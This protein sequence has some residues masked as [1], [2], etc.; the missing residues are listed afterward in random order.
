DSPGGASDA[1]KTFDV[2]SLMPVKY[3]EIRDPHLK[4]LSL[5]FDPLSGHYDDDGVS[6]K[7]LMKELNEHRLLQQSHWFSLFNPRTR[8][9]D[10]MLYNVDEHSGN[11]DTFAGNAAFFRVHVNEGFFVYASYSVVI[12]SKLTQHVVLPPLYE[13]TPHLFTNSEVIQKAYAA[14]MTQTPTKIFAHFT[15]SKS[16]PEQRVAYFGEDIGMNTHHVTWHLEFPFWWD[17]AHYDHHIER[18]GESCSSWV[19]HQLTVRFDAERLSNYL[20]PVRELH[21]DDVIHEGFAPHTSYKYG[22]Y[23]P[24]RPDN[25]NFEDVDG[26]ARVRDM[27]LF[28]ERIQ[29]AIAHGYLRYNGSTINIRDNHGIDVLGDVFE[30]SM[31]SPR[32][33]YYGALHNQAH[34]VLG[35]QADPHGKFALPPGVLEHFETAT[36]DPAFFRLHKYMDNIFRK[37]KD[38]LTPYTKNELKF[39]GVNI[40]SIYEKGNLETYF[41]SF[42]YTGVNIMLLTNDVDDVDIATY[43][44]D[45]AH[46]ELSFQEDVTNEGD[47]GVLETVRIFA[48]PHIDDDHVEFSFNEGRWDVIEMDK[49]WV[50]LEH[51]HHSIDRSSFDSTVTIPDRPSFHDIEDRTSEAI[52]HG[53]ELHIEEF[54]S[55]TG[56]P[57]RFLIP[58][59]LVK[60]KDMDVMVAVTSG[61]GLAAVE[62]LHRSAN[63]AHHGCPE[64][65]Y[66]DKRPHGYPLYRPVDDERII[67]GVTNFK[68]IQVKVFHH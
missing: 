59:G 45:L 38:S 40:D 54:E 65:R 15:G 67:T 6:A 29:D 8:E 2:N 11:W 14:K 46:K 50:M 63:F 32:Q 30:S 10:L 33:D 39:E 16:N 19:H 26:V 41:E 4:E 35:S 3:E 25:V 61:E 55:V 43:I 28:E 9:E 21:W 68:H 17:D 12:H 18:K 1:Q 13:V 37:H 27:L 52:P 66:P 51:G 57:N 42:M 58:K 62:G 36:R 47:I 22:G 23:F 5:S 31:Y 53:K 20:D 60:G 49:F 56:L 7:R 64:V 48:W 44:T 24:D 34:R